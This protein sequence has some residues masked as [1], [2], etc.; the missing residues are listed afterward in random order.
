MAKNNA[1]SRGGHGPGP[2]RHGFQRPKN[3][4][5]TFLR[6]LGYLT[7]YK[8]LLCLVALCLIVSSVASVF[9]GYLL[10]PIMNDYVIPGDFPGLMRMLVLQGGVFLLSA[11]CNYVYARLMVYIAQRSVAGIREELFNKMQ[12]LPVSYFDTHLSG[13]MMSRFTND[14]DTVSEM[15]GNSF[16]NLLSNAITFVATFI[17]M[18]VLNP[19]L[20]LIT[21]AFLL[22][23]LLVVKT[24]GGKSRTNFRRQQ[25]TLGALNGYVEDQSIYNGSSYANYRYRNANLTIRIP[26]EK[27][28]A[29]AAQVGDI[30]N[31]VSTNLTRDDITLTYVDTESRM[32]ALQTEEARLLELL[33]QAET[34]S[35]LLEIES[36]LTDVRYELDSVT[37]RLRTYDNL[38][39]YATIH[40]GIS[41][42]REY[43]PVEEPTL[44]E[45][46]RDGFADSLKGLG[47]FFLELFVFLLTASPYLAVFGGIAWL[48]I[49]LIRKKAAKKREQKQN[50]P[51]EPK[52]E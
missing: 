42:V 44:W 23:M 8:L 34:M 20:T 33:A 52:A 40:L 39:D 26:A 6:L 49:W 1:P 17:M 9:V 22:M 10:K 46:I 4:K 50:P 13:D 31:V 15:I 35:D 3:T 51:T 32:K 12:E 2:G 27:V 28:D 25:Q 16:A 19:L 48:V 43:T 41:E 11:L 45:R 7:R 5:Q 18:L 14:M 47:N 36:R 37:S 24:I 21:V 29:F 30:S 38:V